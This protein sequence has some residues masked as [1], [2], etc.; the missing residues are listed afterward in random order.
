[1]A[2][3]FEGAEPAASQ[4]W[5]EGGSI[6]QCDAALIS[7]AVSLKRIAD[8]M[9]DLQPI[10]IQTS[11]DKIATEIAGVPYDHTPGADNTK[12]RMGL[13]DGIMHAIEQGL[14]SV[15]SRG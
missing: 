14:F 7:I 1:M 5:L 4:A 15:N 6:D 3:P 13:T 2:V 9:R 11:L 10:S 8:T 12:H